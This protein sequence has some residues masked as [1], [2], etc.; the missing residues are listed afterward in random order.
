[1]RHTLSRSYEHSTY[2]MHA[3]TFMHC[4]QLAKFLGQED[5]PCQALLK[6]SHLERTL[7]H[8]VV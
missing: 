2:F 8:N 5:V 3:L 4:T 7:A 1:M 6:V